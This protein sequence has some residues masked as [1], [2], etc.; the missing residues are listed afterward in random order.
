M[1]ENENLVQYLTRMTGEPMRLRPVAGDRL[2]GLPVYLAREYRLDE[3]CWLGK[4]VVLAGVPAPPDADREGVAVL[5]ARLR[6]L[7][8]HFHL[9][10]VLV[11]PALR[12]YQ[13]DRFVQHGIPFIVPG[14]QLFI[15]PFANL[16]EHYARQVRSPKI[17][18]AAQATVLYQ[19]LKKPGPGLPLNAWARMLGYSPMMLTKVR[20]ELV[21]AG[22]CVPA[23]TTRARGLHFLHEGGKLWEKAQ[24]ALRSPVAKQRWI[25]LH[26]LPPEGMLKAGVTALSELTLVEGDLLPT[27]ACRNVTAATLASGTFFEQREHR[28]E[29]N[30]RLECWRY[31]PCLFAEGDHVDRLSLYLSLAGSDDERI[32]LA[33]AELQEGMKW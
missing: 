10:V 26:A 14:T 22:L 24:P 11:V 32:R 20:D 12:S 33:C 13:R 27:Y 7:E 28:E 23:A 18:A 21:A 4:T 30:A 8:E 3:W 16:C 31:D 29:A 17:S 9:P 25:H 19:L 2:K 1:N 6:V 15:P 5:T